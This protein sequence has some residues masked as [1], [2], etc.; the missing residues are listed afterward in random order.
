MSNVIAFSPRKGMQEILLSEYHEITG[1]FLPVKTNEKDLLEA[2]KDMPS[3]SVLIIDDC[4]DSLDASIFQDL[5]ETTVLLLSQIGI[6]KKG[7]YVHNS[8]LSLFHQLSGFL[9]EH[10]DICK[11]F[12]PVP[13]THLEHLA[14]APF[15]I[16]LK[17]SHNRYRRC[18]KAFDEIDSGKLGLSAKGCEVVYI[19][20]KHRSDYQNLCGIFQ[21]SA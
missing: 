8:T 21:K 6:V 9:R 19:E 10:D 1:K 20:K 5:G 15:N 18:A 11:G 16:Y 14:F 7:V 4:S 12:I 17:V 13:I 2:I 3:G